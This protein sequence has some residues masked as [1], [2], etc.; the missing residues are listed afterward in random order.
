M[1]FGG[2][3]IFINLTQELA[4]KLGIGLLNVKLATNL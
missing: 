4:L 2:L 3:R 1:Q